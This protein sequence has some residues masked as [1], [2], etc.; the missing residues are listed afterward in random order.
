MF[1]LNTVRLHLEGRLDRL[2]TSCLSDLLLSPP[3]QLS[4]FHRAPKTQTSAAW[5]A[6]SIFNTDLQLRRTRERYRRSNENLGPFA[7]AVR[8]LFR[9]KQDQRSN[10]A[11]DDLR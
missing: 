8:I 1:T 7:R 3:V 10:N 2:T 11:A 4:R 9:T 6:L 5:A